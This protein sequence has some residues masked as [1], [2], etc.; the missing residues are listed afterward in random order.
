MPKTTTNTNEFGEQHTYTTQDTQ[1]QAN[2]NAE[3]PKTGVAAIAALALDA[4]LPTAVLKINAILAAL[5]VVS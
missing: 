1:A 3:P 2:V 5:K 4:D